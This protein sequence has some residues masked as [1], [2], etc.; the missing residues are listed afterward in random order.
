VDLY[1]AIDLRDGRCVRLRQGDYSDETVYSG[2]PVE[3]A[4][5]FA[6]AGAAWIH[7]V[8]LDAARTGEAA[9][10]GVIAAIVNAVSPLG[11]RVQ[12]GGGVRS[13]EAADRLWDAGVARVVV[14]TAAVEDPGLVADLVARAPAGVAVGLDHRNGVVAVRGW[15][16]GSAR[17]VLD[18]A[19][20]AAADGVGV[21]IV[22][23]IERDGMLGGPDVDGL[24]SV[25]ET[26]APDGTAVIASGG[27]STVADLEVLARV[28]SHGT[29]LAGAITGKAI[30]ERRFT[31]EEGLAACAPSV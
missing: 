11:G 10:L 21:L 20:R 3:V 16:E 18:A 25:L 9:N 28:R 26:V 22:T 7:V 5:E 31:V 27:V 1:P 30:Y 19:R 6:K 23:D 4:T 14:G 24:R 15:V 29:G 17:G 8:D 13:L 2:D 12:S